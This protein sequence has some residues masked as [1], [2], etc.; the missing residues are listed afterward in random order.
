MGGAVMGIFVPLFMQS[1]NIV[2]GDGPIACNLIDTDVIWSAIFG[3]VTAGGSLRLA[4][5]A[6]KKL[7]V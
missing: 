4:Q 3:T 7:P 6:E 1:M 2:F 5:Y